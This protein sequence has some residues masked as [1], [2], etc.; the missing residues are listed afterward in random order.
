MQYAQSQVLGKNHNY[1]LVGIEY[2]CEL[3]ARRKQSQQWHWNL[4]EP[5]AWSLPKM[6]RLKR[7]KAVRLGTAAS[8]HWQTILQL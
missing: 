6:L 2:A 8:D 7:I 1:A 5:F 3:F 4:L